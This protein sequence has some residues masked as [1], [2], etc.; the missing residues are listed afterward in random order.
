MSKD[1]SPMTTEGQRRPHGGQITIMSLFT[2]E[3]QLNSCLHMYCCYK[4]NNLLSMFSF[5]QGHALHPYEQERLRQCMANSARLWELGIFGFSSIFPNNSS[6]VVN[7]KDTWL[8]S[9]RFRLLVSINIYFLLLQSI[10]IL[11]WIY[12]CTDTLIINVLI[13]S[14]RI[15]FSRT[16]A[17]WWRRDW[18]D[19]MEV[20]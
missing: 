2:F 9:I 18:V 3:F 19:H 15:I 17:R 14:A 7:K 5:I 10:S 20:R 1:P 8:I 12:W 13:K 16:L 6:N 11:C 4:N